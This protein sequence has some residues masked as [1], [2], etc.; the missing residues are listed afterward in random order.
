MEQARIGTTLGVG[1][2]GG[3]GRGG[4]GGSFSGLLNKLIKHCLNIKTNKG[5]H[6]E[7]EKID[8][9]G[10]GGGGGGVNRLLFLRPCG[11]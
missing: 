11:M 7:K 3:G 4:T 6:K 9:G 10:G 1:G 5:G 2:G 8:G